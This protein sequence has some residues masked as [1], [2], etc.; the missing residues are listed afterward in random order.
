MPTPSVLGLTSYRIEAQASRLQAQYDSS[1]DGWLACPPGSPSALGLQFATPPLTADS[2]PT[3]TEPRPAGWVEADVRWSSEILL[4]LAR[5]D[6]TGPSGP[7]EGDD[8]AGS[9]FESSG[10]EVDDDDLP[11]V[12]PGS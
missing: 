4:G 3:S 1:G 2:S 6:S 9:V 5:G 11:R 12:R 7:S 10:D 8:D